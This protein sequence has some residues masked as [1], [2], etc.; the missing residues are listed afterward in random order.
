M[1]DVSFLTPLG[2]SNPYGN[3]A[4]NTEIFSIDGGFESNSPAFAIN[5]AATFPCR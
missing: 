5:A 2:W 3:F 4:A 1:F